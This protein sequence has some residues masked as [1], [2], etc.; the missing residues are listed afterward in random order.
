MALNQWLAFVYKYLSSLATHVELWGRCFT[1]APEFFQPQLFIDVAFLTTHHILNSFLSQSHL[2][3]FL[4]MFPRI[5][6]Q[7]NYLHLNLYL[8]VFFERVL[9]RT[10]EM[11]G[12]KC[13]LA[14]H[15]RLNVC[16][17]ANPQTYNS[18]EWGYFWGWWFDMGP[19]GFESICYQKYSNLLLTC[20][21]QMQDTAGVIYNDWE[22]RKLVEKLMG[23]TKWSS[24]LNVGLWVRLELEGERRLDL[25]MIQFWLYLLRLDLDLLR[26]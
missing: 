5:A 25:D 16:W 11:S 18:T 17:A 26:F 20:D 7:I 23:W 3:A 13:K 1:S 2:P 22:T 14:S 15:S 10:L 6:F 8:R 24:I 21:F 4:P 12:K 19:P 9:P